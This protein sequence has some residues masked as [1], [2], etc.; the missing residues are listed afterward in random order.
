MHVSSVRTLASLVGMVAA[1]LT[2][3]CTADIH[4]NT[5][6]VSADIHMTANTDVS[7]VQ[8]GSSV[9]LALSVN[10]ATLVAPDQPVPAGVQNAMFAKIFI[11]DTSSTALVVTASAS[12]NVTIPA[13][14]KAG[15]HKLIC[16]LFLHDGTATSATSE[17]NITVAGSIT[18][19]GPDAGAAMSDAY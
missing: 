1:A 15:G 2:F 9:P 3:A 12:I 11:D 10:N 16:Q 5:V 6:N 8:P 17:I 18:I 14:I 13:T 19:N 4:G 7:N